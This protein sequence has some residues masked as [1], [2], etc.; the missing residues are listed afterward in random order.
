MDKKVALSFAGIKAVIFDMDGT[1]IANMQYHDAAWV[2]FLKRHGIEMSKEERQ[3]KISSRRNDEIFGTLF[4]EETP[5][6]TRK[7]YAEEKE[8][9]Y[10]ELYKDYIKEI[11]G[12]T[13]LI[14]KLRDKGLKLAVATTAPWKN[15][16]FGLEELGLTDAFD[17]IVGNED[18]T[19]GK[20][21]PQIYLEVCRRLSIDPHSCLVFE[22]SPVGVRAGK[23]AG[24]R[25]IGIMTSHSA[26]ELAKVEAVIDD[27][28]QVAFE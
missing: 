6:E 19:K 9:I 8:Q 12:L 2:E 4:G 26:S 3:K 17:V 5:Y 13:D 20:P 1:M 16:D 27:F 10:R 18:V 11:S 28:T 23:N 24:M 7:A 25:V 22:D 15:R 21:D 14:K